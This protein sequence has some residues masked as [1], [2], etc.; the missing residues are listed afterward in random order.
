[1]KMVKD[2]LFISLGAM[3][4]LAYQRYGT[5]IIETVEDMMDKKMKVMNKIDNELEN[6]M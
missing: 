3:S 6:M 2:L 4:V 5:A 1:M